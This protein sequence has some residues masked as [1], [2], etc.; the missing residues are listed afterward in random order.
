M[1]HRSSGLVSSNT[2][3]SCLHV[4]ISAP[5]RYASYFIK[6]RISIYL[7]LRDLAALSQASFA[8]RRWMARL[9]CFTSTV[10]RWYAAPRCVNSAHAICTEYKFAIP[11]QNTLYN[12]IQL[13]QYKRHLVILTKLSLEQFHSRS[14]R[15]TVSCILYSLIFVYFK[16]GTPTCIGKHFRFVPPQCKT[17]V[18]RV[19]YRCRRARASTD[20][21][22]CVYLFLYL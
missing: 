10:L 14:S 20:H 15:K 16:I 6:E 17:V 19:P 22:R 1:Y 3:P 4:N 5:E 8:L 12:P 21:S 7:V 13:A 18:Y 11:G 2:L 9:S